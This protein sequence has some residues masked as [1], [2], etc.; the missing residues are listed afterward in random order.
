MK[1]KDVLVIGELNV[2]ILLNKVE[3]FPV[4]G[5][6]ILADEMTF[7]LGSSSAIFAANLA[8]LG[9]STSFCGI[10]GK[11][12]F[13]EFILSELNKKQVE[14]QLVVVSAHYQT[15][16]TMILNYQQDRAN[17]THCGAMNHFHL[18]DIPA[19]C[20][21]DYKH[22]HLSSYF[23]QKGMQRDIVQLFKTARHK[24]MS[25]SLDIQWDPANKWDFPYKEC[26]PYVDFFLPNEAEIFALTDTKQLCDAF[27][28]LG[29]FAN[30]IIVKRGINGALGY[31]KGTYTEANPYLHTYFVDAI[32]AGD[33]FNAGFISSFL[34]GKS[35]RESLLFGNLAG[36]I[37]TT[38]SGGTGAFSDLSSFVTK[39]KSI[40]NI[41]I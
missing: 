7:T 20:F 9:I 8:S 27:D 5:Q 36:A 41:E 14:T 17:V 18:K 24:G 16:L 22:L 4:I 40:F 19:D 37:N 39:A 25:T 38:A 1:K 32:G 26:L 3:G 29:P 23:L 35:L 33:S 28:L 2:D 11:D 10:V 6:E 13:G 31:N 34:K 21:S 12:F 15:G 30:T